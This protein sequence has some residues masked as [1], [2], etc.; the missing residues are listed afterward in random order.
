MFYVAFIHS[1]QRAVNCSGIMYEI[2]KANPNGSNSM[3]KHSVIRIAFLLEGIANLFTLPLITNT[4][5]TLSLLLRNSAHVNPAS[6]LF[7]RLF[8]G[9]VIG[10]LSTALF[11]GATNTSSGIGSR[12]PTYLMLG[13]GEAALIP[14]LAAEVAKNSGPDAAVNA[15]TGLTM[16]AMLTPLL[17]W[18]FY[19][20]FVRPDLFSG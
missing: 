15:K 13:V 12:K 5:S 3:N 2:S 11:V 14:I 10:G 17:L 16:I 18:R 1:F 6:I 9:V 8:G 20:L 7:A 19:V 4:E